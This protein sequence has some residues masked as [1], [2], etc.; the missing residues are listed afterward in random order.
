MSPRTLLRAFSDQNLYPKT[1]RL[2]Q[3][4]TEV[5]RISRQRVVRKSE[6]SPLPI[7]LPLPPPPL[8]TASAADQRPPNGGL[9]PG[10]AQADGT[11]IPGV[12]GGIYTTSA[13]TLQAGGVAAAEDIEGSYTGGRKRKRPEDEA[14]VCGGGVDAASAALIPTVSSVDSV[15][16]GAIPTPM[17]VV[18]EKAQTPEQQ[19]GLPA[20]MIT[21]PASSDAVTVVSIAVSATTA[22]TSTAAPGIASAVATHMP[23]EALVTEAGGPQPVLQHGS[24]EMGANGVIVAQCGPGTTAVAPGTTAGAS[25]VPTPGGTATSMTGTTSDASMG[26]AAP[27]AMD[28]QPGGESSQGYTGAQMAATTAVEAA[29]KAA[30]T[31]A[32]RATVD[33]QRAAADAAAA[34]REE[35]N[36]KAAAAMEAAKVRAKRREQA[37]ADAAKAAQE[38]EARRWEERVENGDGDSLYV[39]AMLAS[40]VRSLAEG[41]KTEF[42]L[43]Q[44]GCIFSS[45]SLY[46]PNALQSKGA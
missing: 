33:A 11:P 40:V 26:S 21:E 35:A 8:P 13:E 30:A 19:L 27:A 20:G 46:V 5:Q 2:Q 16:S 12:P 25:G 23:Q 38:A 34:V 41:P 18:L 14:A 28:E 24:G 17:G 9:I 31:A 4:L 10:I 29:A 43:D 6:S 39:T 1:A 7:P 42:E 15:G 32:I 37:K 3:H 36:R 22:M 45:R 44:V